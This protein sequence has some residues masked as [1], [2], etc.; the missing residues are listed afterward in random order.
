MKQKIG[1][2]SSVVVGIAV[3]AITPP[4]GLT[5]QAMWSLGIIACAVT[6]WIFEVAPDYAVATAMCAALALFQCVPF[7]TAF[8][9]F[10]E[11]TWWL[12]VGA[13]GMGCAMSK[14]GLLKRLSLGMMRIFPATFNGQVTALILGGIL[15]TP[16]IPSMTAKAA[17]MAPISQGISDAMGYARKSRG[18]AGLFAAMYLGFVVTGPM[19]LS[20]AVGGYMILGLLP[21]DVQARFSW[22]YWLAGGMVWSVTALA[23]LYLAL[24]FLYTPK[25]KSTLTAGEIVAQLAAL[26]PMSRHEKTTATVLLA[27]LLFWMTEPLHGVNAALVALTGLVALLGS[28]VLDRADFRSGVGWDNL[29]FIGAIINLGTVLTALNIDQWIARVCNP[30]ISPIMSNPYLLVIV[31]SVTVFAVRFL[32]VSFVATIA[33]F[34]VVLTP[35]AVKAGINP[36]IIGFLVFVSSNVWIAFYQNS[37]FLTSYYAVDGKMVTHRQMIPF[38]I[39]YCIITIAAGLLSVPYWQY[40][41]LVP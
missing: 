17:I 27:A 20:G 33:I 41:G 23:G 9:S 8:A 25:G 28:G 16:L 15:I 1:G 6:C 38:S 24:L 13:L 10:S 34:T 39:A 11:R 29:I 32:L 18:A 4:D 7:K 2:V 37:S 40:L 35:L 36:W 5:P 26:G 14:S 31:L 22:T 3:S 19:F 12:L 21:V 30:M